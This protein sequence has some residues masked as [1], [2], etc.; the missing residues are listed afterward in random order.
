MFKSVQIKIIL[1]VVMLAIV[2]FV[3]PGCFYINYLS[4]VDMENLSIAINNGKL[5]FSILIISFVIIIL[6][7]NASIS[8]ISGIINMFS[9]VPLESCVLQL[10]LSMAIFGIFMGAAGSGLSIKRYLKVWGVLN[11]TDQT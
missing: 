11:E 1:I 9:F 5:I 10:A 6:G 3:I 7:Y 4:N 8:S 2:M